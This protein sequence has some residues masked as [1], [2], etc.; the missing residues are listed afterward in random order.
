[1]DLFPAFST[2]LLLASRLLLHSLADSNS[3]SGFKR[4]LISS[5]WHSDLFNAG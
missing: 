4:G 2:P 5:H 1:M 3:D